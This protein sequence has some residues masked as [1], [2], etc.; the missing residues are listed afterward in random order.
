MIKEAEMK[1]EHRRSE[2][3]IQ[4]KYLDESGRV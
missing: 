3:N 1:E 4:E 2:E